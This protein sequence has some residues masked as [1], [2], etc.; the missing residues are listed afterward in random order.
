MFLPD[1]LIT[2]YSEGFSGVYVQ[3]P[4]PDEVSK[5]FLSAFDTAYRQAMD[6]LEQGNPYDDEV[7]ALAKRL[8]DIDNE[9]KG[10]D[11]A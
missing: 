9:L 3:C 10:V 5:E 1:I 8:E 6:D 4:N 11:A 2:A 7:S